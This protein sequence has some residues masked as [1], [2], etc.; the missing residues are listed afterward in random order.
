MRLGAQQHAAHE[1]GRRDTGC[2]LDH[3]EPSG[4]LDI[5]VAVLSVAVGGDVI[6]V[7]DVLA[8][9]VGDPGQRGYVGRPRDGFGGPSAGLDGGDTEII[10]YKGGAFVVVVRTAHPGASPSGPCSP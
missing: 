8:A 9:V 6:A 4:C 5:A 1:V 3:L 7:D 10:S 2:A